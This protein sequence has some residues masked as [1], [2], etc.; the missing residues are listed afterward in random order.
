MNGLLDF[1][2]PKNSTVKE[3]AVK[4]QPLGWG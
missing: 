4:P 1:W 3:S 2:C